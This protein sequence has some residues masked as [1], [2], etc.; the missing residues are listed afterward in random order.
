MEFND[1]LINGVKVIIPQVFCD[2][3]GNF[4]ELYEENCMKENGILGKFV[5]DNISTS[6]KGVLRG[7]HTQIQFP[8]AKIVGCFSGAIFDVAVDCRPESSTFGHWHGEILTA[9]NHKQLYLPER[10]AHGFYTIDDARILMKVTTHYT[11]GDEIGFRWD[12]ELININWPIIDKQ[13]LILADKDKT[14]GSF[15]EMMDLLNDKKNSI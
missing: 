13:S 5:Q 10:V 12:D 2:S 1:T 11:P 9:E 8:Q 6:V 4:M 15:N 14:W 7:V 3:R